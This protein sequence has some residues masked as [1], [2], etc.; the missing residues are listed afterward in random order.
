MTKVPTRLEWRAEED[1]SKGKPLVQTMTAFGWVVHRHI[2]PVGYKLITKTTKLVPRALSP[3][4]TLYVRGRASFT[5]ADGTVYEDRV[6]GMYSG[7]RPDTP[8]GV[9][10]HTVLEELEYWCFNWHANRGALPIVEV[11]R[12]QP[13][14]IMPVNNRKVILCY[15]TLGPY[16][17][18]NAFIQDKE[19]LIAQDVC[20][21]F[22]VESSHD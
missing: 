10:T 6:P 17:F 20:Y 4:L 15:G 5:H 13:G 2:L 22:F 8:A 16:E 14:D 9:M 11:F 19:P 7:D 21:G 3:N 1:S 12:L 18:G